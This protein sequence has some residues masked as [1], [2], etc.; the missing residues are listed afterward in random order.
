MPRFLKIDVGDNEAV[1]ILITSPDSYKAVAAIQ[2]ASCPVY[3]LP[4]NIRYG[5]QAQTVSKQAQM[6]AVAR[7]T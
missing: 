2:T 3:D 7:V 4:S 5:S 1:D 6:Y